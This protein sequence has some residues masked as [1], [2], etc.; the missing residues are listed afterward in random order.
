MM[1]AHPIRF[2]CLQRSSWLAA[3]AECNV[4]LCCTIRRMYVLFICC[5]GLFW[6]IGGSVDFCWAAPR[7]ECC[8][9]EHSLAHRQCT[10]APK[11]RWSV[12]TAQ[13]VAF[14][15][16]MAVLLRVL[17]IDS[18]YPAWFSLK[19]GEAKGVPTAE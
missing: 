15:V 14:R 12:Q 11:L 16:Y 8:A 13:R 9:A 10:L 18:I 4:L 2:G 19:V 1:G 6:C 3:R 5:C 7:D 17:I